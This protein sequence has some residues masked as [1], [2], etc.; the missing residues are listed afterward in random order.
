MLYFEH[1]KPASPTARRGDGE[2][3]TKR[4]LE[5]SA[6]PESVISPDLPSVPT[7]H[8]LLAAPV[9][10]RELDYLEEGGDGGAPRV[11]ARHQL[12]I[13]EEFSLLRIMGLSREAKGRLDRLLG[14]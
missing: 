1:C 4:L 7:A 5:P 12:A 9:A 14:E 3:H 8:H 2:R 10:H 13:D 6:Q 11:E